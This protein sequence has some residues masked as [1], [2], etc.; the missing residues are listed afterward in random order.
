MSKRADNPTSFVFSHLSSLT[1]GQ[2]R[3]IEALSQAAASCDGFAPFDEQT[4]LDLRKPAGRQYFLA[5]EA[6]GS[7]PEYA[8]LPGRDDALLPG[9]DDALLSSRD[10]ALLLGAASLDESSATADIAVRPSHRNR[11]IATQLIAQM[12]T[13]LRESALSVWAHGTLP[14]SLQVAKKL[15]MIPT[16][17][18][19]VMEKTLEQ[20]KDLEFSIRG[21]RMRTIDTAQDADIDRLVDLNTRAF[22]SHPEQGKLQ[23]ADFLE[24][25][26][27]PWFSSELLQWAVDETTGEPAAFAWLKPESDKCVELYVLGV[28]PQQQGK[29]IASAIMDWLEANMLVSGFTTMK[30]YVDRANTAAV[31][32]YERAGFQLSELHTC[33][34]V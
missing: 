8:T 18:L 6:D 5:Y 25:F 24:R 12:K 16:R 28:S 14:A 2:A 11:G 20:G 3:A 30:L 1:E 19:L 9:R 10:D 21:L 32:T 26:A 7:A 4:H 17:E 31:R 29:G 33:F 23:R 22:H 27:Q 13:H 15:S 34:Q